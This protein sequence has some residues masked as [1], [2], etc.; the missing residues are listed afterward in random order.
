MPKRKVMFTFTEAAIK[1]PII[2]NL[3]QQFKLVTNI[4]RAD[5]SACTGWIIMDL[6]GEEE[7]M[8]QG[9]AWVTSRGVKVDPVFGDIIEG[10]E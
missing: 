7:D 9:V 10:R 3:G 2:H 5:L 6:E 1:E 4:K 8:E